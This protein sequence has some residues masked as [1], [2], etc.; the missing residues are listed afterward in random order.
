MS[1]HD[2]IVE[3]FE[4]NI[5]EQVAK[6]NPWIPYQGPAGGQGWVNQVTGEVRYQDSRPGPT[7]GMPEDFDPEAIPEMPE[8]VPDETPEPDVPDFEDLE[9]GMEIQVEHQGEVYVGEVLSFEDTDRGPAANVEI[10]GGIVAVGPGAEAYDWDTRIVGASPGEEPP[11]G[12]AEGWTDMPDDHLDLEQAQMVE[13]Y[14]LEAGEYV[15][16]AVL[17][18]ED[19][20]EDG[21]YL[22]VRT[23]NDREYEFLDGELQTDENLLITAAEDIYPPVEPPEEFDVGEFSVGEEVLYWNEH[24][25][26]V[27]RAEIDEVLDDEVRLYADETDAY[28]YIGEY[29]NSFIFDDE[30]ER[31][32]E[33]QDIETAPVEEVPGALESGGVVA[34]GYALM[35]HPVFGEA[36]GQVD[37]TTDSQGWDW[38]TVQTELNPADLEP[39]DKALVD[40]AGV[41]V[42]DVDL[43][44]GQVLIGEDPAGEVSI[45]GE[46][47]VTFDALDE[48]TW[49]GEEVSLTTN[50]EHPFYV[51][52]HLEEVE[53]PWE[54]TGEPGDFSDVKNGDWVRF[55]DDVYR[56]T[57]RTDDGLELEDGTFLDIQDLHD[58]DGKAVKEL[59]E[60]PVSAE[61]LDPPAEYGGLNPGDKIAYFDEE[62]GE[63]VDEYIE[64]DHGDGEVRLDDE[65]GTEIDFESI[66]GYDD[67]GEVQLPDGD[68]L[69]W[70]TPGDYVEVAYKPEYED[71]INQVTGFVSHHDD[72]TGET[73]IIDESGY[74]TSVRD[75]VI[76]DEPEIPSNYREWEDASSE[77]IAQ[78]IGQSIPLNTPGQLKGQVRSNLFRYHR[79]DAVASLLSNLTD[80]TYGWKRD[81]STSM[82]G[83][84][85]KAFRAATDSKRPARDGPS[86]SFEE[87]RV[88]ETLHELSKERWRQNTPSRVYRGISTRGAQGLFSSFLEDPFDAEEYEVPMLATT[89]FTEKQGTAESLGTSPTVIWFTGEQ[90]DPKQVAVYHDDFFRG[91]ND[92]EDEIALRGD[93]MTVPRDQVYL[94]RDESV[95]LSDPPHEWTKDQAHAIRSKLNQYGTS[96]LTDGNVYSEPTINQLENAVRLERALSEKHDILTENMD[97]FQEARQ[98]LEER[99]VN[100]ETVQYPELAAQGYGGATESFPEGISSTEEFQD[101]MEVT[102]IDMGEEISAE[103]VGIGDREV[104]VVNVD[105]GRTMTV[106]PEQI[107]DIH[108]SPDFYGPS[109]DILGGEEPK[110]PERFEGEYPE[111]VFSPY[112][113]GN[114]TFRGMVSQVEGDGTVE[115]FTDDPEVDGIQRFNVNDPT[116]AARI[117][118]DPAGQLGVGMDRAE[119]LEGQ[120]VQYVDPDTGEVET[121]EVDATF[122]S[123]NSV[124]IRD[125][126]EV[127]EDPISVNDIGVPDDMTETD[128]ETSDYDLEDLGIVPNES[129]QFEDGGE[130][131]GGFAEYVDSETGEIIV[132]TGDETTRVDPEDVTSP[133]VNEEV[134]VD[135]P[136]G[137]D[138]AGGPTVDLDVG[139]T[140]EYE[141]PGVYQDQYGETTEITIREA[142]DNIRADV[143]WMDEPVM[144]WE[145]S[146][147]LGEGDE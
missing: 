88:A 72:M 83:T 71:E 13:L 92:Q 66:V 129:I 25:G 105:T 117:E 78:E 46:T 141:V 58:V 11:E 41:E 23:E 124:A 147:V 87:I 45:D 42:L 95:N 81:S 115:V 1:L 65:E 34:G 138:D 97:F 110:D 130:T 120:T 24:E 80:G 76:V 96:I 109:A 119:Q 53:N 132:Q 60:P 137:P 103:V 6:Q 40:G 99:G 30:R 74:T 68:D 12:W 20:G 101:G 22:R 122:P 85:D 14:D 108:Y 146:M 32:Y 128:D 38:L 102:A 9:E 84:W 142:G 91:P 18:V 77:D 62:A 131:L 16:A 98:M 82:A 144:V 79:P 31:E 35:D 54:D 111:V 4:K 107:T 69:S 8:D 125:G 75:A 2:D 100:P 3:T 61:W 134:L 89:N 26:E 44:T 27:R 140:V 136:G 15:E 47:W 63:I 59:P 121:G 94:D 21:V 90:V 86:P 70:A 36:E 135:E 56:V 106:S 126:G 143:P 73:Y 116:E 64:V 49:E 50:P 145:D 52:D 29:N 114:R 10:E 127:L 17:D 118:L 7:E 123:M 51:G 67:T 33:L 133:T 57:N 28:I 104:E 139:D 43:E 113:H 19:W 48:E 112:G 37:V 55:D 5:E 39:G 93:D